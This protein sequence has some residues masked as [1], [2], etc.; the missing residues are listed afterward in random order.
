MAKIAD[1]AT[2]NKFNKITIPTVYFGRFMEILKKAMTKLKAA[3]IFV[4]A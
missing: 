4:L 3:G 1:D 2:Y